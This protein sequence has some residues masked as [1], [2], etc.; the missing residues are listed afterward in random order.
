MRR[1]KAE[2]NV[3]NE[4]KRT[5]SNLSYSHT[6]YFGFMTAGGGV[7]VNVGFLTGNMEVLI[8][9]HIKY[10]LGHQM[11]I[12]VTGALCLADLFSGKK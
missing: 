10:Q 1:R 12:A 11:A 2:K 6:K 3:R 8:R 9:T 7:I 4:D 5:E